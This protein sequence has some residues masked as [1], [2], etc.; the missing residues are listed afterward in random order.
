MWLLF[1]HYATVLFNQRNIIFIFFN[2]LLKVFSWPTHVWVYVNKCAW[3]LYHYLSMSGLTKAKSLRFLSLNDSGFKVIKLL[4]TCLMSCYIYMTLIVS[5]FEILNWPSDMANLSVSG[6]IYH[7][8]PGKC[9]WCSF[10]TAALISKASASI[11]C[12][13]ES[14]SMRTVHF[15]DKLSLF[16]LGRFHY[17][18][19]FCQFG[20][21]CFLPKFCY[22]G[23][24]SSL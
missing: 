16:F 21:S 23:F 11:C 10:G 13:E 8:W 1:C 19:I 12:I 7:K 4:Q 2:G 20:E 3:K 15:R 6:D 14:I 5:H 24:Y 18:N 22:L 17:L 9:L